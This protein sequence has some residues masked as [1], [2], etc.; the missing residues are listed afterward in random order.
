[1]H[2]IL[3]TC[4]LTLALTLSAPAQAQTDLTGWWRADITYGDETEPMYFHFTTNAQGAP[5]LRISQPVAR[6]EDI[7]VSEYAVEGSTLRLPHLNLT[8]TLSADR[9]AIDGVLP[10][11]FVSGEPT[12]IHFV[13]SEPAAAL[14]PLPEPLSPSPPPSWTVPL[15]AEVWGGLARD[16]TRSIFVADVSGHVTALAQSNGAQLWQ[17]DLGAQIR[18]TPALRNG[19]LYVASDAALVALD[20]RTG[21]QIWSAP[22]GHERVARISNSE[23]TSR[24]DHYS[25]GVAVDDEVAVAGSRDGCVHAVRVRAGAEVWRMC[26]EDI[27]TSTPALTRDAVY[28]GGFDH[29][30]YALSRA[31]G[32]L[33]WRYDTHDIV[34]RDAVV[35]GENVL[36]GS[37]TYDIVALNAR[38]GIRTWL[39]HIWYSWVD[40]PPVIADDRIYTGTSDALAVFAYDEAT[41]RPIWKRPVP[42]WTWGGAALGA[43]SVYTGIV[44]GP[45]G[46]PRAGGFAAIGRSDGTLRWRLDAPRPDPLTLYGFAAMPVVSGSR[47][48]AA[49]LGGNV[50]AFDD[51][52][53]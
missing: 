49:D 48:F 42:G 23:A 32:R 39:R 4:A 18:S 15:N 14:A 36:F 6:M 33:L 13:R 28:F 29:F 11:T 41:G 16:G 9:Q 19:K 31:D 17:T 47:I 5:R 30:A 25:S 34:P 26:T 44:G 12:P 37:R 21:R 52:T 7:P 24:W 35:A 8:F 10:P 27:V 53:G 2:S 51:P 20:A 46:A 38:T 3:R 1:M 45:Y 40:S 50:Y 22:F 43:H